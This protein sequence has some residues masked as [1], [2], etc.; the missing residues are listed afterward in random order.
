MDKSESAE[1]RS[2]RA[3]ITRPNLEAIVVEKIRRAERYYRLGAISSIVGV[4]TATLVTAD[5]VSGQSLT[6]WQSVI[7]VLAISGAAVGA[8][9]GADL[10]MRRRHRSEVHALE[11]QTAEIRA[12]VR[13]RVGKSLDLRWKTEPAE[14]SSRMEATEE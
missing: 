3:E 13:I 9:L 1:D 6:S 12:A 10:L 5:L 2:I 4:I 8:N 14:G 11:R 7:A